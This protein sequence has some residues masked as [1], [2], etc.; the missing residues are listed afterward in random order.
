MKNTSTDSLA[1]KKEA[2][3]FMFQG[4][5]TIEVELLF[6]KIIELI[7]KKTRDNKITWYTMDDFHNIRDESADTFQQLV[8]MQLEKGIALMRDRSYYTKVGT[9]FIFCS[10]FKNI[11]NGFFTTGVTIIPDSKSSKNNLSLI[12]KEITAR[13]YNYI[14]YTKAQPRSSAIEQSIDFLNYVYDSLNDE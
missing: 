11:R 13:L 14:R 9:N 10:L 12:G 4:E 8:S 5:V 1:Q 7:I 6:N 3:T 2:S